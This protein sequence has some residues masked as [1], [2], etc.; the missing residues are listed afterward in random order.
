MGRQ[1]RQYGV[2]NSLG[3]IDC[4]DLS[5]RYKEKDRLVSGSDKIFNDFEIIKKLKADLVLELQWLWLCEAK[6]DIHKVGIRIYGDLVPFCKYP[7]KLKT[8]YSS[9]S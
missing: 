5:F 6:I 1:I 8:S 3:T 2:K 9:N 7:P 4:L